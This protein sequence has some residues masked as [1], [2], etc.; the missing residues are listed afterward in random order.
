MKVNIV[1]ADMG[2]L[3]TANL[4]AQAGHHESP[5][6]EQLPGFRDAGY[7]INGFVLRYC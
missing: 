7:G 2:G 4:P 6:L 3:A 5:V 1:G